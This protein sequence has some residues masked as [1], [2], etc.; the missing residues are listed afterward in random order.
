MFNFFAMSGLETV[1][2]KGSSAIS[3]W[4]LAF[5]ARDQKDIADDPTRFFC[6]LRPK[7]IRSIKYEGADVGMKRVFIYSILQNIYRKVEWFRFP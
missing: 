1:L 4:G 6:G 5:S 2:R 7:K 3:F